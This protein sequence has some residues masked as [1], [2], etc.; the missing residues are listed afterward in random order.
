MSTN[1]SSISSSGTKRT[2]IEHACVRG[3]VALALVAAACADRPSAG[4]AA[5]ENAPPAG[6]WFTDRAR[7]SGLDFVH[8]NGMTGGFDFPEVIPPGVALLDYDGD[9]DLDMFVPQ[10][11]MLGKKPPSGALFPPRLPPKSRLYRNDLDVH[12]DGTRTL[13]FVDVTDASG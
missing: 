5:P 11:Q 13:R 8:F 9:G 6:E 7:E 1:A 3:L 4:K 10:G 2:R 12:P